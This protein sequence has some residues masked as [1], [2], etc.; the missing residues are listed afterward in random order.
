MRNYSKFLSQFLIYIATS[1]ILTIY[2]HFML[3]N[4]VMSNIFLSYTFPIWAKR[5]KA[6]A[7]QP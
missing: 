2:L 3:S 7:T 4:L 5:D 6:S 1:M